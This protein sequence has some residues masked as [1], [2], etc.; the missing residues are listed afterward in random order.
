MTFYH[1]LGVLLFYPQLD[2]LKD[3]VIINPKYFVD[4]LGKVLPFC[5]SDGGK[6]SEEWKLFHEFGILVQ[7]LYVEVWKEFKD[8][9]PEFFIEVLVYFRLAVEV[10]TNIHP[11]PSKQ[12]FMSLVLA[13]A[14][15]DDI[16]SMTSCTDSF[17]TAPLHIT[18]SS[19]YV[20]PGFFTRFVAVI[21]NSRK[22]ELC[23]DKGVYRNCVTF[24]YQDPNI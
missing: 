3:K 14:S 11:P 18:F 2:G 20:P 10:E 4:A 9:K 21:A 12:Y 1:G 8:L 22:T 6:Y 7:P 16:T 19:G 13:S 5:I 17:K 15:N 24:R 23:F